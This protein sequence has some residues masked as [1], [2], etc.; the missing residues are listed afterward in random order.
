MHAAA[1]ALAYEMVPPSLG[2][3][4][5]FVAI[6]LAVVA[7]F[8]AAVRVSGRRRGD[9]SA[10]IARDTWIAVGVLGL[11]LAVTAAVTASGALRNPGPP[12]GLMIFFAATNLVAIAV[13]LSRVGTRLVDHLPIHAFLLFQ[14]FRLP[15]ELVLHRWYADGAIPIQMTYEGA[16]VDILSGI[17]GLLVG[18]LAY[19]ARAS[20]ALIAAYNAMGFGLLLTVAAIAVLSAPLPL[21]QFHDGPPL[22]LG[23]YVPY[24]W[25]VPFCVGGALAA[26]LMTFRWLL[27]RRA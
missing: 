27:R 25:I 15:L 9:T 21:R 20:R 3:T 6:V 19:R 24:S 22:L 12:P 13:A 11:Y 8:A 5:A 16:N 14:G 4:V 26:H 18:W 1:P 7:A 17:G 23:L 10:R 2:S